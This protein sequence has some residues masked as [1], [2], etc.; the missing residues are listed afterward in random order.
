ML[1]IEEYTKKL[2]EDAD[3]TEYLSRTNSNTEEQELEID[4]LHQII[5]DMKEKLLKEK[6]KVQDLNKIIV[7]K[8]KVIKTLEDK[9]NGEKVTNEGPKHSKCRYWNRGYCR[10]G[11][12]CKYIHPKEDCKTQQDKGKCE[13]R[14]C[15]QRHRRYCRYY[16]SESGCYRGDKCHYLHSSSKKNRSDNV[17]QINEGGQGICDIFK[18]NQCNFSSSQ[19]VTLKKHVNTK[20]L[21]SF[22]CKE[23]SSFINRLK[24]EEYANEYKDYFGWHGFNSKEAYHVEE[25][26]K[27]HGADFI[28]KSEDYHEDWS[29]NGL[30]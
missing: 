21:E 1:E 13:D 16:N 3:N 2:K 23:I 8:N 24:L 18:C 27:Q 12:K 10:E 15:E 28:M 7:Q 6:N 22:Y 19:N 4:N 25:M 20:H 11:E 14:Q 30:Y 9:N 29:I 26:V 17:V 5:N